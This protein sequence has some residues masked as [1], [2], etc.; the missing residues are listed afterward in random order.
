M[1][2]S[3]KK[4]IIDIVSNHLK[5]LSIAN[6]VEC[7]GGEQGS[8]DAIDD[9][10]HSSKMKFEW[11]DYGVSKIVFYFS[12]IPDYV[13]KIPFQFYYNYEYDYK[14]D[15][16]I[17]TGELEE[18]SYADYDAPFDNLNL[19]DYCE[20]EAEYYNIAYFSHVDE[21]FAGTEYL[22]KIQNHPIYISEKIE[23]VL[24]DNRGTIKPSDKAFCT[25]NKWTVNSEYGLQKA[26]PYFIDAYGEE[27]A[28]EFLRFLNN[29]PI[30]DFHSGNFGFDKNGKIK[31]IDYSGWND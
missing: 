10:V 3:N 6:I 5:D 12:D 28:S 29:N 11:Y 26:M 1:E 22:C 9:I 25:A 23:F 16:Y 30:E 18:F 17:E 20:T 31:L 13:I 24:S 2:I 19:W 27:K 7:G 15:D 4:E 8:G 21:C 14:Q